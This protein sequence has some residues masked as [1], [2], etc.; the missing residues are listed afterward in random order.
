[1]V[2]QIRQN[3]S[4]SG[5]IVSFLITH[6]SAPENESDPTFVLSQQ[7]E[8]N[9]SKHERFEE[10][11]LKEDDE[12]IVRELGRWLRDFTPDIKWFRANGLEP[13]EFDRR[14]LEE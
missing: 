11:I 3:A 8:W 14:V 10:K 2:Q 5:R 4:D 6:A 13:F 1:M 7:Y 12:I 9:A